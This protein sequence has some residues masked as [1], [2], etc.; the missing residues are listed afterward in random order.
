VIEESEEEISDFE[1][2]FEAPILKIHFPEKDE[3]D[4]NR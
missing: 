2:D 1:E 3:L 4:R